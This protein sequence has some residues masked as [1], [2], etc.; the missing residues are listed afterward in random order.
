[1]AASALLTLPL[2]ATVALYFI[3]RR[4]G[5]AAGD[6]FGAMMKSAIVVALSGAGAIVIA[7][8]EPSGLAVP[9]VRLA[10]AGSGALVGWCIGLVV[11][12]H[13]LLGQIRV[14]SKDMI[15]AA[16]RLSRGWR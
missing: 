11:T 7:T 15:A 4:L 8:A 2:Q 9:V 12:Q 3:G 16:G 13:P 14:L 5:I 1:M 10:A 6:L